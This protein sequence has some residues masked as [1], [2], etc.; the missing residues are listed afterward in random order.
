MSGDSEKRF[1]RWFG[2]ASVGTAAGVVA[3]LLAGIAIG[4]G[5][6][7]W[8]WYAMRTDGINTTSD[9]I[10]NIFG[11]C[12]TIGLAVVGA[13]AGLIGGGLFGFLASTVYSLLTGNKTD[14]SRGR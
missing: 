10:E 8:F 7:G 14:Q 11:F 4:G 3:G 13:I 9:D 2:T 1:F 6:G 5:L 12:L